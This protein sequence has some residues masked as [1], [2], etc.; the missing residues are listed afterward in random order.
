MGRWIFPII[1]SLFSTHTL[2]HILLF[3]SLFTVSERSETKDVLRVKEKL[4]F[5]IERA[6]AL[7]KELGPIGPSKTTASL[8]SEP[9][10][11]TKQETAQRERGVDS[12]RVELSDSCHR[13]IPL[14]EFPPGGPLGYTTL[15]ELLQ[16][17]E[18]EHKQRMLKIEV[19]LLEFCIEVVLP[20]YK[21]SRET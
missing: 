7:E 17:V 11:M 6:S 5:I 2:H 21:A 3:N 18:V 19:Q 1:R 8:C 12:G 16:L 14:P 10:T 4:E 13:N 9:D 15:S 20:K